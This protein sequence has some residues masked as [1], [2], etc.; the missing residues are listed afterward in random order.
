MTVATLISVANN[1]KLKKNPHRST[2]YLFFREA[3]KPISSLL[4][5]TNKFRNL[6]H[7]VAKNI[8]KGLTQL[9]IRFELR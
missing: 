1:P 5:R 3:N 4:V 7:N 8:L 2:V 6:L 9:S